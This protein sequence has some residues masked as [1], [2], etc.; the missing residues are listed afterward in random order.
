MLVTGGA[1]YIGA[2]VV[3]ALRSA[4]RRV[5]VVDDLSTGVAS[6]VDAVPLVRLDLADPGCIGTLTEAIRQ[7]HVSAVVHLAAKKSVPESVRRPLW[8]ARQNVGGMEHLLHA[9]VAEPAVRAVV[10]SS[11]AAVYGST[12]ALAVTEDEPTEPVNPYGQTKL[13]GEW[14][15]RDVAS[16]HDV[17]T[18]ALRYFN[19]AGAAA[20]LLADGGVDNLVTA[21]IATLRRGRSPRVFGSD[22]PTPDGT[23][24]RDFVAVQDVAQAHLAALRRLESD[25]PVS[26][27]LNV[28]TG[29]GTSVDQ[30]VT[31]LSA[32]ADKRRDTVRAPSYEPRRSGDPASVVAAVERIH[33]E[34]GWTA[35]QGLDAMLLSAWRASAG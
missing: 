21:T 32:L 17:R 13:A 18:V 8:Y 14:L 9:V 33:A 31:R 1:G 28:G 22:Y 2:H 4:G 34:L 16:T 26:V 10:F 6:R 29:T 25:E 23:C 11:S 35:Q 3:A 19:V 5:L 12:G 27:A 30:V 24:V 7:H 15:L 20:P